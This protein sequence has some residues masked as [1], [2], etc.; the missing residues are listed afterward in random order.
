MNMTYRSETAGRGPVLANRVRFGLA[1]LFYASL[2][3][4]MQTNTTLQN[5]S[6]FTG[7]TLMFAYAILTAIKARRGTLKAWMNYLTLTLDVVIASIVITIGTIGTPEEAAGQIRSLPLYGV[8]FFFILYSAFLFSRNFVLWIGAL[9]VVGQLAGVVVGYFMGVIYWE[10]EIE[11]ETMASI[12][13]SDQ[14]LKILFTIAAAFTTRSVIGI[15]IRMHQEATDQYEATVA[16]YEKV[17]RSRNVM[18][19][20]SATLRTSIESVRGFVDRFNDE[21]QSQAAT[22]EE[23]SAAVSQFSTGTE[24]SA[25]SVRVQYSMFQ[26]ISDQNRQLEATLDNI[27]NSTENLQNR[28]QLASQNEERVSAAIVEVN[29]SIQEI[30]NSFQR[31]HQINTIM[32]EIAD[33]TNLLSL[34]AAIEAARAGDAGRG[35]AVVAGEVGRLAENSSGNAANIAGIIEESGVQIERGT[36]AASHSRTIVESQAREILAII[37]LVARLNDEV[38]SQRSMTETAHAAV[39]RLSDLARELD[40]IASEQRTG[41]QS[42]ID[43]LEALERGVMDLVNMSRDMQGEIHAIES[44]AQKLATA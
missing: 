34:N 38:D 41:G 39:R 31:V 13:I 27:V 37:E 30:G 20:S 28:M 43:S 4:S 2:A 7:T 1:A 36:A 17:E 22:F 19:E 8:F 10:G 16:S 23:I 6:Y 25:D 24:R 11:E 42:I 3:V 35:F 26:E 29:A 18:Q 15:L 21:L 12:I 9:C 33:R 5:I 44:Q 14:V 32:S 40:S